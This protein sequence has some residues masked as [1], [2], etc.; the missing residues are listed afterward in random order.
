ME[1]FLSAKLINI[2]VLISLLFSKIFL[3]FTPLIIGCSTIG[4]LRAT[5]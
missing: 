5:I 4:R 2:I 1:D 3:Y